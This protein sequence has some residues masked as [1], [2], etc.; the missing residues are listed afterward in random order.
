MDPSPSCPRCQA[1]RGPGPECPRCGVIYAKAD[2]R[3]AREAATKQAAPPA[4]AVAPTPEEP[5][6][7]DPAWLVRPGELRSDVLPQA[8]PDWDAGADEAAYERKLHM[9]VIPVVLLV[10]YGA[11]EGP[12]GFVVRLFTMPLH[13]LGHAVSGWLC[14]IVAIPTLWKT[15][16][17][18]RSY[19]AAALAAAGLGFWVF[20]AWKARRWNHVAAGGGLLFVQLVGTLFLSWPSAMVVFSFGGD[21]GMMLLGTALMTTM[22]ARPGSYLHEHGLRWGF[23]VIGGTSF[24]DGFL[25]WWRARTDFAEIPFGQNEGVGLSDASRLVDEHGWDEG[26]L[27]RR[28]V[29]LG[30]AC[31]VFL[32]V[33]YTVKLVQGRRRLTPPRQTAT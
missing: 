1:P 26:A 27:I 5:F 6:L 11:V 15:L 32:A 31:L 30:V 21:A 33:L 28:Y 4:E 19:L 8:T 10:S 14:G 23:V 25:T 16:N 7:V 18:G 29:A 20:R 3:A 12:L 24:M 13:E 9:W 17:L 22:Y 2:A